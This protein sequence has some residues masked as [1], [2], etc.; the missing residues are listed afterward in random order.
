ME[1][2]FF[3][4][5]LKYLRDNAVNAFFSLP[6]KVNYPSVCMEHKSTHV[7]EGKE[8][9]QFT[10]M[11]YHDQLRPDALVPL[12]R[13]LSD[14]LEKPDHYYDTMK[15]RAVLKIMNKK[16]IPHEYGKRQEYQVECTALVRHG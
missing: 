4:Y 2:T 11:C 14:L 15:K 7:F 3:N 5:L 9:I 12:M 1:E 16:Q 13:Q 6:L 8:I 10:L